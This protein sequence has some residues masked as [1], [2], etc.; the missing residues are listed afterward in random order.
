VKE[1]KTTIGDGAENRSAYFANFGPQAPLPS[2]R[3]G[4]TGVPSQMAR[5]GIALELGCGK[6]PII[7]RRLRRVAK[8]ARIQS[9]ATTETL[10]DSIIEM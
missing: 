3:L 4:T 8:A 7:N 5:C 2:M 1:T 9:L 6:E 10:Q